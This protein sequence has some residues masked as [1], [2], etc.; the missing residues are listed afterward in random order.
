MRLFIALAVVAALTSQCDDAVRVAD[1]VVKTSRAS[2]IV[3]DLGRS[4]LAVR[5]VAPTAAARIGSAA[6]QYDVEVKA[7]LE[8]LLW[9]VACDVVGG[10]APGSV[11]ELG[12]YI[13]NQAVNFALSISGGGAFASLVIEALDTPYERTEVTQVCASLPSVQV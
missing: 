7:A 2:G 9:S 6:S 12:P 11:Q 13:E 8:G 10:S 5:E 4:R 3:D 1:D